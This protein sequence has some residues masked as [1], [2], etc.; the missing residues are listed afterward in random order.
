MAKTA[1]KKAAPKKAV[2]KVAATKTAKPAKAASKTAAPKPIKE[3]LSKTGLVAHIAEATQL[4]PKE[5]RAVLA[6]LE[7]AAH[8]SLSKKGAGSFT[9]PGM[10]KLTSVHVPAKPKRKGINP[11]T[12]EEQVFA[13]KPA[14]FKVRARVAKKLKDSA[15]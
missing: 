13:A 12:K 10:L 15:L 8:A 7:G 2:K 9:L 5:V 4:A 11:F 14:G 1:A 3:A 6:A